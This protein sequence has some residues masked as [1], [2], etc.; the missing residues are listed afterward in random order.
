SGG[1][2]SYHLADLR[3][4]VVAEASASPAA[5]APTAE[6]AYDEFGVPQART[7]G[8]YGWLGAKLRSLELESGVLKMGVRTYIPQLGRFA[9]VDPVDGGSANSYDY[10]HQDPVNLL[11]LDGRQTRCQD[12]KIYRAVNAPGAPRGCAAFARARARQ[13]NL[14]YGGASQ[15]EAQCRT[16]NVLLWFVPGG[17][18][19]KAIG[20]RV[21]RMIAKHGPR[22]ASGAGIIACW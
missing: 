8:R 20:S 1:T 18:V 4:N 16:A 17:K 9:Q 21:A 13:A 14:K 11:D 22:G 5:V 7:I 19:V 2:T 3:D 15:T 10:V 6:T 12:G